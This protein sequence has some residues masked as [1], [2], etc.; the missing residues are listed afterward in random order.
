MASIYKFPRCLIFAKTKLTDKPLKVLFHMLT[1]ISSNSFLGGKYIINPSLL[2]CLILLDNEKERLSSIEKIKQL[3]EQVNDL[4]SRKFGKFLYCYISKI[5]IFEIVLFN[6]ILYLRNW[7]FCEGA[8][9]KMNVL[10]F[11]EKL[12]HRHTN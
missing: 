6:Q 2:V 5:Y 9:I 12:L 1:S 7:S 8:I 4:F 3:R 10:F 11:T